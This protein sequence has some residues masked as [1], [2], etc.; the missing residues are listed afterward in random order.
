[1]MHALDLAQAVEAGRLTPRDIV[2]AIAQAVEAREHHLH[3]FAHLDLDRL[4]REAAALHPK[5]GLFGLPIAIKDIIETSDA[6]TAYGSRLYAGHQPKADATIVMQVLA[7]GGLMLGKT[8]TTEFAYLEP[9]KSVNPHHP[10]ATPGGSSAGSAVA[11]AAGMAPLAL[12]TQTGGSI[13]R[14]AS[15]CGVAAIKPSYRLLPM[16]RVQAFA[17]LLDTLGLFGASIRDL[18]FGLAAISGRDLRIDTKDFGTPRFGITRMPFAGAA[19]PESEAALDAAI[20]ALQAAGSTTIDVELPPI[21]AEAQDAH[22]ILNDYEGAQSLAFEHHHHADALSAILRAALD[23]GAALSVETYDRARSTAHRA[24]KAGRSLFETCDILLTYSAPGAAPGRESTG[25]S[26]F[27]KL[28]TLLGFPAVNVPF[29][30]AASGLPV[31]L[32]VIAPFGRDD[33]A[34]GAAQYLEKL[35]PVQL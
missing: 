18:A 25:D 7:A 20:K 30:C 10:A 28:W 12:G 17:P 2:D 6:P 35:G 24:R 27:N 9:A 31:G 15:F 33:L 21:M 16:M 14:P 22:R 1:M 23:H 4:R 29:A 8:V 3:A 11:V 32:Q 26:R 34:L 5:A 19:E 13:I